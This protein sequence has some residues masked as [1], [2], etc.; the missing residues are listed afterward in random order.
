M[1]AE[2]AEEGADVIAGAVEAGAGSGEKENGDE[3]GAGIGFSGT[4]NGE[5]GAASNGEEPKTGSW[6][7]GERASVAAGSGRRSGTLA[8]RPDS[9]VR[10]C[11]CSSFMAANGDS[12][13][14]TTANGL[15]EASSLA[16]AKGLLAGGAGANPSCGSKIPRLL[17]MEGFGVGVGKTMLR[18][19]QLNGKVERTESCF[20]P[21]VH[22]QAAHGAV[23]LKLF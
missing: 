19:T 17:L 8:G 23:T 11:G 3:A 18:I 4:L 7:K 12:G 9:G 20:S 6:L 16:T 1:A 22:G 14:G 21:Q 5:A 15:E 13:S 2:T 10:R